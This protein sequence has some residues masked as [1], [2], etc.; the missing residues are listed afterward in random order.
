MFKQVGHTNEDPGA[1]GRL[2]PWPLK[3]SA[4]CH[5]FHQWEGIQETQKECSE[6]EKGLGTYKDKLIQ[7]CKATIFQ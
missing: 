2:L 7:H 4:V 5:C 6:E 1:A 3:G